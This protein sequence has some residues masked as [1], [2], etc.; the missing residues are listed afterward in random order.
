MGYVKKYINKGLIG[1]CSD[2]GRSG[3]ITSLIANFSH[4]MWQCLNH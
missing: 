4:I 3:D 1:F 2:G